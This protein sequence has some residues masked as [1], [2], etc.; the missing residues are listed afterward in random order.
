ML[1]LAEEYVNSTQ[2]G[3]SCSRHNTDI[4]SHT[5]DAGTLDTVIHR[6]FSSSRRA[7]VDLT[8][9]TPLAP[10]YVTPADADST[11]LIFARVDKQKR[12]RHA[13]QCNAAGMDYYSPSPSA[14]ACAR[15]RQL[16]DDSREHV[17]V[18]R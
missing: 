2:E 1:A 15:L 11:D 18:S 9:V 13:A 17:A 7:G 8:V 10:S 12:R 14:A 6:P 5:S 4:A 16:W 3:A